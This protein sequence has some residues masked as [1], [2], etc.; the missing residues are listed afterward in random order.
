MCIRDSKEGDPEKISI[1]KIEQNEAIRI[2]QTNKGLAKL[3]EK[4]DW[5]KQDAIKNSTFGRINA[6]RKRFSYKGQ[7]TPSPD[8]FP[9]DPVQPPGPDGFSPKYAQGHENRYKRLDPQSAETMSR[10]PTG[11]PKIDNLVKKQARKKK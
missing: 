2:Y 11:D 3:K 4:E 5:K 10:A 1:L 8:G 9:T 7:P 6:I